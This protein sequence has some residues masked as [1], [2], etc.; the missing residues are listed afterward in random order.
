MTQQPTSSSG[1]EYF[2]G[3]GHMKYYEFVSDGVHTYTYDGTGTYTITA[4]CLA[5][6]TYEYEGAPGLDSGPMYGNARKSCKEAQT[7]PLKV[8]NS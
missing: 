7:L 1:E 5:T 8:R 4:K 3:K 6:V 2:D